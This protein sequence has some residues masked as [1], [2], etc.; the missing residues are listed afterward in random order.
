[1]KTEEG[2]CE[3]HSEI[4]FNLGARG[5]SK[6]HVTSTITEVLVRQQ[7]QSGAAGLIQTTNTFD[8]YC[9]SKNIWTNI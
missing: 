9:V 7:S 6:D 1:M 4:T 2:G 8:F 5:Q 3:T